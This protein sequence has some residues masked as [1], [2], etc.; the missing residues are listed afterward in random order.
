MR[1]TATPTFVR[2]LTVSSAL[3]A[4]FLVVYGSC[5]WIASQRSDVGTIA[6]AW[7]RHLPFV[8]LMIAPYMSID[9]FFVAAPFVCRTER[10]LSVFAKRVAAAIVIAG[11][12]FLLF[13]LRFAFPRPHASGWTGA[14]FNWFRALDAPY[15]LCPSLHIALCSLL[16]LT[17]ARHTRGLLRSVVVGWFMLI[18]AS[19]V[20]TY[21][22]HL[23]DVVGGV[24]LAVVCLYVIRERE[25]PSPFVLAS[26]D[27]T[28]FKSAPPEAS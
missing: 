15:N 6:F 19:A 26:S 24:A 7:E 10:E 20:L 3:S 16:C 28:P 25:A 1:P 8:P 21:Q 5:N 12:C 4:L 27:A 13:P 11:V 9:F 23:L 18:G 22:H 2:R 17:Y 14:I